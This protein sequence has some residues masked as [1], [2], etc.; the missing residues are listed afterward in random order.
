MTDLK[1]ALEGIVEGE[2]SQLS[3]ILLSD[4]SELLNSTANLTS[5]T[6]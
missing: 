3:V 2:L 1:M 6:V 4:H 5:L